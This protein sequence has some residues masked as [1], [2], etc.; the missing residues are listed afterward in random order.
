MELHGKMLGIPY[1]FR[2]PTLA[3][4]KSHYWNPE[5]ERIF[6]PRAFGFGWDINFFSLR[7]RYPGA[8]YGLIVLTVLGTVIQCV[9]YTRAA[10]KKGQGR[11]P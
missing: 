11:A 7:A 1:D 2:R 3:K 5:D 4:L 8:F 10:R 6:I 9:V